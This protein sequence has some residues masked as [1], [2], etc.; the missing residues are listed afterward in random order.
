MRRSSSAAADA[1]PSPDRHFVSNRILVILVCTAVVAGSFLYVPLAQ[2][3]PVLCVLRA[4]IGIPCPG[5]GMTRAFCSLAQLDVLAALGYHIFSL[6]FAILMLAAPFV[7]AA[8]IAHGR[9]LKFYGFLY[10]IRLAWVVAA[11]LVGYYVVRMIYWIASGT[12]VDEH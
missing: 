1:P 2:D 11:V 10:S 7:A 6:P 5:C 4:G 8:E 9:R 12:F 3:G